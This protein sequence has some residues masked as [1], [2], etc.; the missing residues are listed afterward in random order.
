[1]T[2]RQTVYEANQSID[3]VYFPEEG[4]ISLVSKMKNGAMVEIGAVGKEGMV[5]I[6][7]FLGAKSNPLMAFAQVPGRALRMSTVDFKRELANGAALHQTLHRYTQALFS[8]LSQSVGC[9]RLHSIEQ[10]CARWLLMTADRVGKTQFKLTQ[11][12]LAQMLGVRRASVN[13]ILQN[14]QKKGMLHYKQGI[15]RIENR[16][17][18]ERTACECYGIIREEYRKLTEAN[19]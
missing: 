11:D 16:D 9:N 17:T 6:P 5:G 19:G 15:M 10:R 14:F 1:M 8:Q 2:S 12:F 3:H 13:P 7:I 4:V 18:L